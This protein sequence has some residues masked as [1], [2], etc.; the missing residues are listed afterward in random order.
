MEVDD[1][2]SS[3]TSQK[4]TI[5]ATVVAGDT[6]CR[7]APAPAA[8][9]AAPAAR[10]AAPR[11]SPRRGPTAWFR[12]TRP[13]SR[14]TSAT[15]ARTTAPAS[16]STRRSRATATRPSIC[17]QNGSD[18]KITMGA[19]QE[20]C[21]GPNNN[22]TGNSTLIEIQDCNGSTAQSYTAMPMSA[23]GVYAF[24]NVASGPLPERP[25]T[26]HEQRRVLH[27]LR[28][29]HHPRHQRSVQRP[30]AR[31][32]RAHRQTAGPPPRTG[33]F[34]LAARPLGRRHRASGARR[35]LCCSRSSISCC[36]AAQRLGAQVPT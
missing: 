21:L 35:A 36:A 22:G 6:S 26:D 33:R 2:N 32:N 14:S 25:G 30:V 10:V 19:N 13:A 24:K 1:C 17:W 18:W 28:L 20:K 3:R 31:L 9:R 34:L 4:F 16:S 11:R 27:P 29:R 5:Q 12:R 23:S 7:P 8:R 15:A